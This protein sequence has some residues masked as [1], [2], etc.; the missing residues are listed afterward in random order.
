MGNNTHSDPIK[1]SD[2]R[3]PGEIWSLVVT[4]TLIALVYALVIW[5]F[6]N[7]H[8][9]VL[10]VLLITLAGVAV[11]VVIVIIQ[12]R[13]AIGTLVHVGPRQFQEVYDL[14]MSAAERL[15]MHPVPVYVK[16]SSDM[17]IYPLGLWRKPLIV[18]TSSMVDQ[19]STEDLRFYIA[20]ELTHIQAGHTW[21][22]VILKPLGSDVAIIGKLLNSM[23]FGD[24]VNRSELT[25]DRGGFIVCRSLT[26]SIKAMLKLGVGVSLF[27][28]LD[29][30]EFLNQIHDVSNMSGRL[31]ELIAGQL[32]LTQRVRALTEF[33]LSDRVQEVTH[34]EHSQT[35]IIGNL[36]DS[37]I[38][39]VGAKEKTKA[40]K[41]L[42]VAV[43]DNKQYLL[44]KKRT[45]IGRSQENDIV[46][47]NNQASRHHADI[48]LQGEEFYIVDKDSINGVLLNGIRINK[49][50]RITPG[51][52]ILISNL[53][54]VFTTQS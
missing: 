17:N 53:E 29:I 20:R 12:Q 8:D 23:I 30:E 16:R 22:R 27:K 38:R 44:D 7:D 4:F 9:Q 21:L 43:A 37:F 52:C 47:E 18:I 45:G 28:Q 54:Y 46:V 39:P 19:L 1:L 31:T 11:Y 42:L 35:Q 34:D 49:P 5:I 41:F 10:K 50:T 40:T 6:P 25:A 48:I 2:Y 32:Y 33:A 14:S 36:P 51:D 15:S 3:Y 24:W 26:T 13:T